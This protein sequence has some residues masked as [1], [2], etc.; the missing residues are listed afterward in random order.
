MKDNNQNYLK[1]IIFGILAAT[2]LLPLV[3][4]S[5]TTYPWSFGKTILFQIAVDIMLIL[6]GVYL[7]KIKKVSFKFNYLDLFV[8][9][10]FLTQLLACFLGINW[11]RSWWGDYSRFSGVFT[12]SHLIIFYFILR[13]FLIVKKDWHNLLFF[14]VLIG[15][16]SSAAAWIGYL[17]PSFL[18]EIIV[19]KGQLSGIIGNPIF[20]AGYLILPLVFSLY[21]LFVNYQQRNMRFVWFYFIS[22]LFLLISLVFT[23]VRGAFLGILVATIAFLAATLIF[24]KNK[25][26]KLA[27]AS[28]LGAG[29]IIYLS[30]FIIFNAG[31]LKNSYSRLFDINAVTTTGQTRLLSWGVAWKSISQKPVI[32]WGQENYIEAFNYNYNQ[33]FL[34]FAI[35]ETVWDKPHN[36]LL[37]VAFS[38][39]IIGFA[40]YLALLVCLLLYFYRII[41]RSDKSYGLLAY[42][43]LSAGLV[44]YIVYLFFAF[45][46]INSWHIWFIFMAFIAFLISENKDNN[47]DFSKFLIILIPLFFLLPAYFIY[48]NYILYQ[49]GVAISWARDAADISSIYVW[50][51]N[52]LRALEDKAPLSWQ[53]AVFLVQDLSS[54][55]K[56]GN[57]DRQAVNA[58]CPKLEVI[59]L[60]QLK[61][62]PDSYH[63]NFWVS[64]LYSIWGSY[65]DSEYLRKA[66]TY[67]IKAGELAPNQQ[68]VPFYLAKNYLILHESKEA[69]SVLRKAIENNS[70][71]PELR[72]SLGLTLVIDGNIKEGTEQLELGKAFGFNADSNIQYLIDIYAQEKEYG[73]IIPLYQELIARHPQDYRYYANIAATYA[74]LKDRDNTKLYL[75]KAVELNPDLAEEAKK[76]LNEN[77][78]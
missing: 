2:L 28:F 32:G 36:Y 66:N 13:N 45:E 14:A 61:K 39:G 3:F 59:F 18:S 22:F 65:G 30:F 21:L 8:L 12:L 48:Q 6:W 1:K 78:K 15:I 33:K 47:V 58:V 9:L 23:Q 40:S 42:L 52:A 53:Q 16:I 70:D 43:S 71:Y 75:E 5:K 55:D 62:Y 34:Q 49:S 77:F 68:H 24:S 51:N 27:V 46:T 37:E 67:L 7:L 76:F 64:Q 41:Q 44:C 63:L 73:K 56:S 74:V 10:F 72:W 25:K 57:L 19:Y 20:F 26:V 11:E 35:K 4:T 17:N 60:D 50:Q 31:L 69:V 54:L 38:S 29:L